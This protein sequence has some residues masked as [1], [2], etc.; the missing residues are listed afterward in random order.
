MVRSL[1]V[2]IIAEYHRQYASGGSRKRSRIGGRK[3]RAGNV[4]IREC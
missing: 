2:V 1:D 3:T 4:S